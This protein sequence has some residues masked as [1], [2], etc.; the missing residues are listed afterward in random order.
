MVEDFN[1]ICCSRPFC[2]LKWNSINLDILTDIES[3]LDPGDVISLMFL[4]YEDPEKALK[5]L[6]AFQQGAIK[7][8][9]NSYNL[10]QEWAAE[11]HTRNTWKWELMEALVTCQLYI[12]IKTLGFDSHA[13]KERFQRDSVKSNYINPS[14][15]IFYRVCDAMDTATYKCFKDLIRSEYAIDISNHNTC[16][17]TFLEL[18][19]VK[20]F[21]AGICSNDINFHENIRKLLNILNKIPACNTLYIELKTVITPEY[22]N[23]T[24]MFDL[25]KE[26]LNEREN[27]LLS[28]SETIPDK[29]YAHDF[30]KEHQYLEQSLTYLN[31]EKLKTDIA[32]LS[33]VR[34]LCYIINQETFSNLTS[35]S[36]FPIILQN[37]PES[38][39][40]KEI[41]EKTMRH[42]N[43]EVISHDNLSRE[44]MFR[45]LKYVIKNRVKKFHTIFM[46][47]ILSHGSK[48]HVY[49][50]DYQKVNICD[51]EGL[52]DADDASELRDIP[53]FLIVQACQNDE[54]KVLAD[55]SKQYKK[56]SNMITFLSTAGGY[57]AY[58]FKGKGSLFIHRLCNNIETHSNSEHLADIFTKVIDDFYNLCTSFKFHQVPIILRNTL[59][60]KHYL[61]NISMRSTQNP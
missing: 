1:M 41:L 23:T 12:A 48:D 49:S 5:N 25:K 18:L 51:I 38:A 30:S 55:S 54:I 3:E 24:K 27:I 58:R 35:T 22:N 53:K 16:E 17:F 29:I 19:N 39:A 56:K 60:G 20:F 40:D 28:S 52:L 9:V 36:K 43:I 15:K 59:R 37:R 34:G 8:D 42:H 11:V 10:L 31:L 61:K 33:D 13:L 47:F 57:E 45:N 4:L 2:D 32:S 7:D 21:A 46:L 14:R 50:A 44:N 26:A 6:M